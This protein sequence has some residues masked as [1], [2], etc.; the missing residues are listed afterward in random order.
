MMLSLL[1]FLFMSLGLGG[2]VYKL[3]HLD[4]EESLSYVFI[5]AALGLALFV[6]LSSV[7]GLVGLIDPL[8]Y[9]VLAIVPIVSY[10]VMRGPGC[11]SVMC[12]L[13]CS[14]YGNQLEIPKVDKHWLIVIGLFAVALVVFEYG[15][16]AT[17]LLEDDDS[18]Q[19]AAGVRYVSETG[20]YLQPEPRLIHYLSPYPPFYD[21]LMA[22]L[23]EVDGE[24]ITTILK[25]F[26]AF[27]V[28]LVIPL[29]Y[30]WARN[31]LD[32]D[33]S[34]W[35]TFI[36]A[37][38]P[39]F[40]SHFIWSQTLAMVFVF[41]AL[42]FIDKYN[43]KKLAMD[44]VAG[45]IC[46]TALLITQPSVAGII[47]IMICIYQAPLIFSNIQG[48]L[49][50]PAM[51]FIFAILVFWGGMFYL[52]GVETVM[53]HISF[54]PDFVTSSTLD[55][56][57]GIVYG[58]QDFLTPP[59]ASRM[60]QPVGIG[61]A[62]VILTL[63]GLYVTLDARSKYLIFGAWLVFCFIGLQA[64]LLPV[65]LMPHR[66][67]VFLSIP[68]AILAAVGI[69]HIMAMLTGLGMRLFVIALVISIMITSGAAKL[70]VETS[71][72][73]SGVNLIS[74]EQMQGYVQL[75][76]LPNNTKVFS[77]CSHEDLMNGIGMYGYSWIQEVK[78]YKNQSIT[79]TIGNNLDF[80]HR[81]NYTYIVIDQACLQA[82][83]TNETIAKITTIESNKY[84]VKQEQLSNAGFF[85]YQVID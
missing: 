85:T 65:K 72:W 61:E 8:V 58:V 67:W 36:L 23:F 69:R 73:P 2:F 59:F 30:C 27:L 16:F 52:Y 79:D 38:L 35:A 64:N 26:N 78:D 20:T 14:M 60:D 68:V 45:I 74:A 28:A 83:T 4:G 46:L 54:I 15:A 40:M 50:I 13:G 3:L 41:P 9:L 1:F 33:V 66:F 6:L 34:L 51:S 32:K 55:T 84:F 18:W 11:S 7:L 29:F 49:A 56:G 76:Q 25:F 17:P 39:C 31:R 37:L 80:L 62:V 71:P 57:G 10:C 53:Q 75:Q 12:G 5:Y 24:S 19:H 63:V 82:F 44:G 70:V 22:M 42:Y 21:V 77:F 47:F 81:Y 48:A 43:E